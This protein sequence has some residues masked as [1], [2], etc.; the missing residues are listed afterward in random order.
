MGDGFVGTINGQGVLNQVIG[1]NGQEIKVLEEHLECEC[2][3]RDFDHRPH[4]DRTIGDTPV[5]QLH[6]GV[7]NQCHGL[8]NLAGMDQ[9]RDQQM[10]LPMRCGAQNGAQL[11]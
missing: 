5:V 7:I 1:T 3:R 2:R 10:H 8:T 11:G 9:H 6:P 4:L